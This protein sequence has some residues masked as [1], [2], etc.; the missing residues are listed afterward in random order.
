MCAFR[1]SAI[2]KN[3]LAFGGTL[4]SVQ[5]VL[6]RRGD[7]LSRSLLIPGGILSICVL[8]VIRWRPNVEVRRTLRIVT[9]LLVSGVICVLDIQYGRM[10]LIQV[11]EHGHEAV[12]KL[13]LVKGVSATGE[14]LGKT[15]ELEHT[16]CHCHIRP[17]TPGCVTNDMVDRT[18]NSSH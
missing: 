17:S 5:L 4:R 6:D 16:H 13:L 9:R 18:L 12:V 14:G 2:L 7:G 11:A 1:S 15:S 3:L 10:P 8:I